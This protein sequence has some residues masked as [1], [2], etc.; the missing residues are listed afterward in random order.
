MK[1]QDEWIIN[2]E[3]EKLTPEHNIDFASAQDYTIINIGPE[4]QNQECK[5]S[6]PIQ[7]SNNPLAYSI[8]SA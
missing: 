3:W 4:P 6:S 2:P 1:T 7:T 5:S 8:P